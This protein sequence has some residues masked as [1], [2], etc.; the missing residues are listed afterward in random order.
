MISDILNK[1]EI[2]KHKYP[3]EAANTNVLK[4]RKRNKKNTNSDLGSS[5]KTSLEIIIDDP[6]CNDGNRSEGG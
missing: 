4:K 5:K 2:D 6:T 1:V 3:I